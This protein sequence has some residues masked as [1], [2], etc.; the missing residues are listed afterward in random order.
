M[1]RGEKDALR[2][3]RRR[4]ADLHS[5]RPRGAPPIIRTRDQEIRARQL[6]RARVTALLLGGFVVLVFA[7]SI[8]KIRLGWG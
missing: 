8:V 4:A 2:D 1:R 6:A 5:P 3:A 7:I